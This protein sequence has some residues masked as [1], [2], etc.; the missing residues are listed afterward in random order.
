MP[1]PL[2]V[3]TLVK[4][5]RVRRPVKAFEITCVL[6]GAAAVSLGDRSCTV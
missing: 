1:T 4:V 5:R 2:P 6:I 3:K